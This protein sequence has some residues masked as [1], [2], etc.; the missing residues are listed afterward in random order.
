VATGEW[1]DDPDMTTPAAPVDALHGGYVHKR[2]VHVL[3]RHIAKRLP[4]GA[5]VLDVGCGDGFLALEVS[6]LRPDVSVRGVDVLIREEVAIPVDRFDGESI[7]HADDSFDAV[8]FV[9]VLH[10][11]DD[12]CVLLDEARRVSRDAV[13][14]KDH[15]LDGVLAGPTLRFMDHVGNARHG[16][17]LPYNY[18]PRERWERSFEE[19]GLVVEDWLD[20]LHLYPWP[21]DW[22][23][24]RKLHFVVRL[25]K[26]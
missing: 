9:D 20:D 26:A 6:K 12:P 8:L 25:G 16:V 4:P 13:V 5:S 11:T 2:R 21:A 23:F 22:M 10:H 19:R 24:G 14:I 17:A 18:W 1:V 3:S 7:Q 15:T